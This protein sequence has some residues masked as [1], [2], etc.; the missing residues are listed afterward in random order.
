MPLSAPTKI[1]FGN[2]SRMPLN[3][4]LAQS[5]AWIPQVA[6]VMIARNLLVVAPGSGLNV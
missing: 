2:R 6:A 5:C 3:R 4:N 1:K